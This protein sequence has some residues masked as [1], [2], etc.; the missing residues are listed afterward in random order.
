MLLF[1]IIDTAL[2]LSITVILHLC[3]FFFFK[4][5]T[6]YNVKKK[7]VFL[8]PPFEV[9]KNSVNKTWSFLGFETSL[10][11]GILRI[12][13]KHTIKSLKKRCHIVVLVCLLF[14][15]WIAPLCVKQN[16]SSTWTSG[17]GWKLRNFKYFY[18]FSYPDALRETRIVRHDSKWNSDCLSK[19]IKYW[20]SILNWYLLPCR[21]E[22]VPKGVTQLWFIITFHSGVQLFLLTVVLKWHQKQLCYF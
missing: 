2:Q 14:S 17:F 12:P 18:S 5:L 1:K 21:V 13:W 10:F 8:P 16:N 3:F 15:T 6:H 22:S 11:E 20:F 19:I 7:K 9:N 4:S